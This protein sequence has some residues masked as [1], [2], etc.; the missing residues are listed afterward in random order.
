MKAKKTLVRRS[1]DRGVALFSQTVLDA[2]P[3]R[4]A[5]LARSGD[6]VAI[7]RAWS[8]AVAQGDLFP[9]GKSFLDQ[10]DGE[11]AAGGIRHKIAAGVRSVLQGRRKEFIL[12]YPLRRRDGKGWCRVRA[13]A[14][15]VAGSRG[16]AVVWEDLD[17]QVRL[18]GEGVRAV[19]EERKRIRKELHDGL[20]QHLTGMKFKVSLLAHHLPANVPAATREAA[21]IADLVNAATDEVVRLGRSLYPVEVGASA[22]VRA[23]RDLAE[24]VE[25]R[26]GVACRARI[27]RP[28]RVSADQAAGVYRF[29]EAAVGEM[30]GREKVERIEIS[31]RKA[32]TLIRLDV[33][34]DGG[35]NPARVEAAAVN[36]FARTLE[37]TLTR[38]T[39]ARGRVTLRCE[40]S[41]R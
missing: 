24:K 32:G 17:D 22:L 3:V 1:H 5:L 16:A 23:L 20:S 36:Y 4:V 31:L 25:A 8:K 15:V 19:E 34:A 40:F 9:S 39:D 10:G 33:R 18:E 14:C 41:A 2:L 29:A 26:R 13:S 30:L 11:V 37:A 28:V 6:V 35:A 7:N 12:E 27:P 38:R 21:G